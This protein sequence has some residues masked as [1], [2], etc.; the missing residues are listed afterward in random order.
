MNNSVAFKFCEALSSPNQHFNISIS[1][2]R[3]S[4]QKEL[5][6]KRYQADNDG[7]IDLALLGEWRRQFLQRLCWVALSS[8]QLLYEQPLLQTRCYKRVSWLLLALS[9]P[10]WKCKGL[11]A[12]MRKWSKCLSWLAGYVQEEWWRYR[13]ICRWQNNSTT[14]Q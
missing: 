1:S 14:L 2:C 12:P 11:S 13:I 3:W 9:V 5:L 6:E 10:Q 4:V 7:W 8:G